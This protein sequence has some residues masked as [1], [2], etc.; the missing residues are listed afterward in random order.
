MSI[1]HSEIRLIIQRGA[2]NSIE[3]KAGYAA[4]LV[5]FYIRTRGQH[6][7]MEAEE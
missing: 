2:F 3:Q 6:R 5:E 7:Q 1:T 4:N